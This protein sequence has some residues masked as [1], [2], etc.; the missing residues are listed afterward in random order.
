MLIEAMGVVAGVKNAFDLAKTVASVANELNQ[1][2]LKMKSAE[3]TKMVGD[4]V[5]QVTELALDNSQLK[6]QVSEQ[7]QAYAALQDRLKIRD[8]LIHRNNLYYLP[9]TDGKEDGAFC[10]RCFDVD[11]ILVHVVDIGYGQWSCMNC[12]VLRTGAK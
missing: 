6:L 2:D 1:V 12:N 9:K 5:Q 7:K 3:L 8:Q 4:L 10:T 11:G